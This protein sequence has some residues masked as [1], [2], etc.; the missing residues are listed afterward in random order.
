[1]KQKKLVSLFFFLVISIHAHRSKLD[2]EEL[3][4]GSLL[5]FK[6][7]EYRDIC[8]CHQRFANAAIAGYAIE[9][10]S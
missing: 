9:I 3:S 4:G 5:Y 1:M 10:A 6:F 7:G 8:I 2:R